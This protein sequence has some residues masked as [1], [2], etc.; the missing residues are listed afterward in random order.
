MY[1]F[2]S[3]IPGLG[4]RVGQPQPH[5]VGFLCENLGTQFSV[6]QTE[7]DEYAV[8]GYAPLR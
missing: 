6:N 7:Y 4:L 1:T 5:P 2:L 8:M 3:K